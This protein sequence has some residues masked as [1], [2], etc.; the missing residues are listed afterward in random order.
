[1][2]NTTLT[3]NKASSIGTVAL[4]VATIAVVLMVGRV[5]VYIATEPPTVPPAVYAPDDWGT[6]PITRDK[7]IFVYQD[8]VY[9]PM[10]SRPL[11]SNAAGGL[12]GCA[13][14]LD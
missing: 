6:A 4:F 8:I 13:D 10:P 14:G 1:M 12:E 11:Y 3:T 5:V 2:T 7:P 9:E